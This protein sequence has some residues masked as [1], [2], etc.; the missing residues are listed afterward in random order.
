MDMD[1]VTECWPV[2][3]FQK[4]YNP[5]PRQ[6]TKRIL[7]VGASIGKKNHNFFIDLAKHFKE[8]PKY[9]GF[10][11]NLY[12]LGYEI[13]STRK[14]NESQGNP[15]NIT[16]AQPHEMPKVYRQ[17]DWLVYT[18]CSKKNSVGLPLSIAEAQASGIGVCLQEL[19]GRKESFIEYIG[20]GYIFNTI[21][22]IEHVISELCHEKI[23]QK[24]LENAKKCD[25][26]SHIHLLTDVWENV[27]KDNSF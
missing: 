4:F 1:K 12:I 7:G 21:K 2:I 17:H 9:K 19:P 23:I 16:Y 20:G 15:T 6:Q 3:S 24:G 5:I 13:E 10:E 8:S 11:F 14:Y 27:K 25:I 18:T 26:N 22:D